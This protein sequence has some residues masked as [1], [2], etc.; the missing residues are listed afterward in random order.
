M[1]MQIKY[2]A[3]LLGA[4]VAASACSSLNL[5]PLDEPSVETWYGDGDQIEMSLNELL[6]QRYWPQERY[7]FSGSAVMDMDEI[8][9]DLMRRNAL[10]SFKNG[11]LNAT[12]TAVV[13]T[14]KLTYAAIARCN[15]IL[16]NLP[17]AKDKIS[18]ELYESYEGSA[19]FYRAC[20]YSRIMMLYGDP[21]Y[22]TSD[23]SLEQAYDMGRTPW[24]EAL[25]YVYEDF[26]YAAEHCPVSYQGTITRATKGAAYAMKARVALYFASIYNFDA[27]L[28]DDAKAKA[29]Y[30]IARDAAKACM[31]LGEYTLH[32]DY[33]DLFL[34]KTHNAEES[35]FCIPRSITYAGGDKRQYLYDQSLTAVLPVGLGAY[36]SEFP[37]WD[38][39]CS[40][41]CSDG[42]PI[43]KSPL[44]DPAKPFENRDPRL[45]ASIVEFGTKICGYTFDPRFD[46][47]AV[48]DDNL[49]RAVKNPD[50]I[51][52]GADPR[53]LS[54]TGLIQR[55]GID[56]D[57][58]DDFQADPDKIIMRFADVLLMYAESKIELDQIDASTLEAINRVRARA[59]G[60]SYTDLDKYPSVTVTDQ[61]SLRT[62]LRTERR[63]EL[64][65]ERLRI[66]DL[67]RWRIAE[68][69][70]NYSD[71]TF[72]YNAGNEVLK[73][74]MKDGLWFIPTPTI[75]EDGCP[76]MDGTYNKDN[77]AHIVPLYNRV[78][79]QDVHYL[80]PI[81]AVDVLVNKNLKQNYGY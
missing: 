60:V 31:D 65:F 17:N 33:A 43:D 66:Y 25:E 50:N 6:R 13:N 36:S 9:D 39:F 58:T 38:L 78:F 68:K 42:L 64:A 44:Y 61:K 41:L 76:V 34:N 27:T 48:W 5:Y 59:Y 62:V 19:R 54:R 22:Y 30:E 15:S 21:V 56:E 57:W 8:S 71:W 1:K 12:Q 47:E 69:V 81:P 77:L 20:F 16:T 75:D 72:K 29:N 24:P 53:M 49:G 45:K 51:V 67:F 73:K 2:I 74:V 28:K 14:W 7:E 23:I 80:W 70:I 55:K 10:V 3:L 26:D 37:T 79:N 63:M 52:T 32:E 11:T 46:V 40:Y 18:P 35:V 4:A